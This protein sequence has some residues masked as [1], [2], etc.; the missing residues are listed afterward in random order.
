MQR[1]AQFSL[2]RT[3]LFQLLKRILGFSGVKTSGNP[4]RR[5]QQKPSPRWSLLLG[6]EKLGELVLVGYETPWIT[7]DFTALEGFAR[8]TP[9]FEW[10]KELDAHED[11]E[12]WESEISDAL[13]TLIDEVH[14][15]G[16]FQIRNLADGKQEK[17]MLRFADD[18]S[19]A[20][21]R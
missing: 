8:F 17:T 16:G 18:Y 10:C 1:Q 21:F 6:Q 11:D 5:R 12:N 7:A 14:A 19:W 15:N 20:S 2:K 4:S 9:Y 3:L 13:K